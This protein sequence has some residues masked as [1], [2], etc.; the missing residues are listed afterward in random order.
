MTKF[1]KVAAATALLVS[2]VIAAEYT[3]KV[4]H[5][6]S[7]NTPKGKGADFFAKRVGRFSYF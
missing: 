1:L 5:V 7:P 2:S 6:V 3:I 4:T